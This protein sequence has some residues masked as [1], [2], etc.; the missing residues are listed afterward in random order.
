MIAAARDE[1]ALARAKDIGADA[2]IDLKQ[3]E[4]LTERIRD[5]SGGQLDVVLDP[6]WGIPGA[7]A[8]EALSANGRFVQVGQAAGNEATIKSSIVRGRLLSILG[9]NNFVMPW[10]ELAAAYRQL[11]SYAA[12]G[13]L[14]VEFEVLPLEAAPEAW[15]QQATSPH[16]KLVLSPQSRR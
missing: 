14:K 6:V 12:A 9:Y 3:T 15:K 5:A 7:A 11:V 4:G 16:R 10:E 8:M 13:Q 2:T 1:R